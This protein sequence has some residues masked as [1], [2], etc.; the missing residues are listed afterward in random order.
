MAAPC[1][2]CDAK[3]GTCVFVV[4]R[5]QPYSTTSKPKPASAPRPKTLAALIYG[6]DR[7]YADTKPQLR[8]NSTPDLRRRFCA[9]EPL[10]P[11]KPE[12]KPVPVAR[13]PVEDE[14][15]G[16][17]VPAGPVFRVAWMPSAGSVGEALRRAL[18]SGGAPRWVAVDVDVA[19][20]KS[21]EKICCCRAAV[22]NVFLGDKPATEAMID[23]ARVVAMR[24]RRVSSMV[25]PAMLCS[26][27]KR[28]AKLRRT[29]AAPQTTICNYILGTKAITLKAR[30]VGTLC[31][32]MPWKEVFATVTPQTFI[33]YPRAKGA[34]ERHHW[35]AAA[36]RPHQYQGENMWIVKSSHGCKG[37]G[38]CMVNCGNPST[39]DASI[40]TI[41]EHVDGERE[42]HPWVVQRYVA[43]PLLIDG[44]K[45]DIRLWVLV[46]PGGD[47]YLYRDGVC[48]TSS[49]AYRPTD[50]SNRLI[51]LTNHCLQETGANY[52][53]AEQGN[54]LPLTAIDTHALR[55]VTVERGGERVKAT[56]ARDI[57]PQLKRIIAVTLMAVR[58]HVLGDPGCCVSC[59]QLLGYDFIVDAA[60]RAWLL[61]V[62]G[63]PG[64]ANHLLEP[65]VR[66]MLPLVLGQCDGAAFERKESGF[67]GI[68]SLR[69]G[70][71]T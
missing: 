9:L 71:P 5:M 11:K 6:T 63:S 2:F 21:G 14:S 53:K 44:R 41:L 30:M 28:R 69:G 8:R 26:H 24:G 4:E 3:T 12:P 45:F 66:D 68:F 23:D 49:E 34:D 39:R 38:I 32:F 7:C 35:V 57:L 43:R 40:D 36:A 61:E 50:L 22:A 15:A 47:V 18:L 55:G 60:C 56:Y 29:A 31:G 67:D 19:P 64:V 33:I 70:A 17:E 46:T 42:V 59:F 1:T 62:N 16:R 48:R 13:T 58:D 25:M 20:R 27:E 51:H 54:E 52:S 37:S 65:M 10:R